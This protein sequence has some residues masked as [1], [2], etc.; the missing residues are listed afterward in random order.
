MV[1]RSQAEEDG[2]G[3]GHRATNR[4][5][6][7]WQEEDGYEEKSGKPADEEKDMEPAVETSPSLNDNA[8]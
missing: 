3:R 7:G 4:V 6:S 1:Q 8:A 5:R 2:E